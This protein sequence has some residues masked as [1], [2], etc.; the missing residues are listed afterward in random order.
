MTEY[1]T[2]ERHWDALGL[3]GRLELL[4]AC[5]AYWGMNEQDWAT[6]SFKNLVREVQEW[7]MKAVL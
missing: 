5:P 4:A 6:R 2:T 3:E 1:Q 7:V